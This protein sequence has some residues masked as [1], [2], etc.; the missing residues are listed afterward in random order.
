MAAFRNSMENNVRYLELDIHLTLDDEVIVAHDY[1]LS[2]ICDITSVDGREY[3]GEFKFDE[4]PPLKNT[5][6]TGLFGELTFESKNNKD[7][8]ICKLE[9]LFIYLNKPENL[10]AICNIDLKSGPSA[11]E[12][13]LE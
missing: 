9:E 7:C 10:D 4:L 3:I 6:T 8:K 12:F 11:K 13:L 2:R 1:D 5:F